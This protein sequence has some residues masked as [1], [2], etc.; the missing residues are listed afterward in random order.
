MK[1]KYLFAVLLII[2]TSC[3]NKSKNDLSEEQVI[4][5]E[6]IRLDYAKGFSIKTKDDLKILTIRNPWQGAEGVEY[7]YILANE[8]Q[9][10][11]KTYNKYNIIRTPIKRVICLSTTHVAFIDVLNENMS[12]VA[13]S[14]TDYVNNSVIRSK[15]DNKEVLDIGYDNSLN[16]ELIVSLN[17]DLV[18]TYGV[19][20][21]VA[22]Y[23]QKLNDLGIQTIVLAEYLE[24]EPLGKLEW[25]KLLAALYEKDKMANDYFNKIEYEYTKLRELTKPLIKKPKVLI[26]LP[27]K[28]VWYVPGGNSYLAKMIEDAGGEYLWKMNDSKESLPFDIESVFAK[29]TKTEVWLHTGSVNYKNEI[30]KIDERFNSFEPFKKGKIFNNNLITNEYGG[31]DY[32]ESGLVNPQLVLK[33]LIRIFHPDILP[34]HQLVYYKIIE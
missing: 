8:K 9:S 23:N 18:I 10:I 29:T 17:P 15:I 7:E 11:P 6:E 16:Y 14:G 1:F 34:D 26:G 3:I 4:S 22:S 20:G 27:W 33:D 28:D 2:V 13:V 25:I 30:L 12:V 24:N 5:F 19:G 31:N 32:W 21:E